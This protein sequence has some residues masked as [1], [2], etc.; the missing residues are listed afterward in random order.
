MSRTVVVGASVAGVRTVQALRRE[1]FGGEVILI[2]DEP[3]FPYDKPPLS[4]AV[5]AGASTLDDTR[6]LSAAHLDDLGLDLRLGVPAS[7]LD[8]AA[9]LVTLADG[10]SIGYDQVVLATGARARP[11]P[12]GAPPGLHLL[13]SAAHSRALSAD[14]SRASSI[15]VI[16]AGFIGSE[17]AAT[18]VHRGLHVTMVDPLANPMARVVGDEVGELLTSVHGA[19]GVQTRLGVGVHEVRPHGDGLVIALTDGS[20]VVADVAVVGIGALPNVEWLADSGLALDDGVTCD[21]YCRAAGQT[22]IFAAGDVARWWHPREARHRRVEHWTH[23]VEQAAVVGHNLL[24]PDDL[25]PYDPV[26][27]VW[28]DQYDWRIQIAGRT[29]G[30]CVAEMIG[31]ATAGRFGALYSDHDGRFV[32]AMTVNWQKAMVAARR[33]LLAT[34]TDIVDARAHMLAAGQRRAAVDV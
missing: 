21:E 32:G 13:R 9:K 23:A 15:V 12:W 3:E 5:F 33:L 11:S 34:D 28:S 31:D 18:A 20:D 10:T 1:G 26:D 4:K 29:S 22:D 8:V 24:H 14:L 17:V 7:T 30:G 6:L 16:G 27:Y 25:R 2:G 19:H